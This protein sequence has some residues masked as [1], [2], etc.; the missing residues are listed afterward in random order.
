MGLAGNL[1]A[2]INRHLNDTHSSK[3]DTLS[4]FLVEKAEH[5][6]KLESLIVREDSIGLNLV[7]RGRYA[8]RQI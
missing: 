1:I 3:C 8:E 2:R 4:L 5:L 6:K 7:K